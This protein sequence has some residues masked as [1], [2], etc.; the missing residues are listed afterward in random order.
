MEGYNKNNIWNG[1]YV[2]QQSI[3]TTIWN[4]SVEVHQK[5][6]SKFIDNFKIKVGNGD[7]TLFWDKC[8]VGQGSRKA[9]FSYLFSLSLQN[10]GTVGDERKSG[11]ESQIQDTMK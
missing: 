1:E 4:W 5:L 8:W 9:S 7:K 3:I 10:A 6:W 2:D 11:M